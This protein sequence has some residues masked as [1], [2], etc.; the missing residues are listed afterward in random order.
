M[1]SF[2]SLFAFKHNRILVVD[3][4]EFCLVS[5][6]MMLKNLGLNV[7]DQI[8]FCINGREAVTTVKTAYDNGFSYQLI[9]TDFFMPVMNGY[10]ET[11]EIR[12]LLKEVKE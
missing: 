5:M 4:E 6:R 10:E 7:I 11:Q 8:D 1:L 9:L 3:D 12:E 2:S